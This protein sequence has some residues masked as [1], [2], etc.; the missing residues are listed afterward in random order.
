MRSGSLQYTLME[1]L[2]GQ[3]S[4]I[5]PHLEGVQ[6]CDRSTVLLTEPGSWCKKP[7]YEEEKRKK[8]RG[9][10]GRERE[11]LRLGER[12]WGRYFEMFKPQR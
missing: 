7:G 8:G 6:E 1:S 10:G 9:V 5:I 12:T 11:E 4:Y 3:V 2:R